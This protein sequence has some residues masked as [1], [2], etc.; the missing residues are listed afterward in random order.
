MRY[1]KSFA[2]G[3]SIASISKEVLNDLEIIIPSIEKQQLIFKIDNLRSA[4][5]EIS[6]KLLSLKQALNQQQLFNALT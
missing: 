3:T 4:E 2:R 1:L 6:T 5:R